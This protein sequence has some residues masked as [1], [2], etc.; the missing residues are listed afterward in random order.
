MEKERRVVWITGGTQG[1]GL[2]LT[3][4]F[5]REGCHVIAG[6]AKDRDA[7]V[8]AGRRFPAHLLQ[9]DVRDGAAVA[10]VTDFIESRYGRLDILINNAG[11]GCAGRPDQLDEEN[12]QR[13]LDV[14]VSGKYRCIRAALP[15]LR[16]SEFA[17]IVNVASAAGINASAGMSAYCVA[18]AGIIM[19]TR[20]AAKD[21]AEW[22]IRVNC[23]SP[24]MM[25]IGMS[26]RWFT[27]TDRKIVKEKNYAKN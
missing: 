27:E 7:A 25:D 22:G 11:V 15:L 17:S 12:F 3:E 4:H 19:L 24:S 26:A 10:A 21:L 9:A 8:E 14:N 18:A 13:V 20:C 5:C 16:R 23:I 1:L 6:Y 2:A